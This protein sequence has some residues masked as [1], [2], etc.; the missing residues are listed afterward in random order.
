MSLLDILNHWSV[1][2]KIRKHVKKFFVFGG[3]G[4]FEDTWQLSSIAETYHTLTP[5]CKEDPQ[6]NPNCLIEPVCLPL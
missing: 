3:C 4:D 5:A 6:Q 1:Q 2:V